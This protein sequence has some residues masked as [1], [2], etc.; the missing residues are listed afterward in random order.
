MRVNSPSC[1]HRR[2][3]LPLP[4]RARASGGT[5]TLL[6]TGTLPARDVR[7]G[8]G[9]VRTWGVDVRRRDDMSSVGVPFVVPLFRHF[10]ASGTRAGC[11][12]YSYLFEPMWWA[13]MISSKFLLHSFRCLF[14][15]LSHSNLEMLKLAAFSRKHYHMH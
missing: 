13:G 11:G 9:C 3:L 10:G 7:M 12:G 1:Y 8:L 15:L 14:I 2:Q 5:L 4:H 6:T